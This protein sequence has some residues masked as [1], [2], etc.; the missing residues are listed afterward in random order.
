M[1]EGL[2]RYAIPTMIAVAF[3]NFVWAWILTAVKPPCGPEKET[4]PDPI[5][6]DWKHLDAGPEGVRK[7]IV[8]KMKPKIKMA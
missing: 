7:T 8:Q 1:Y 2:W 6:P 3:V 5:H 4:I